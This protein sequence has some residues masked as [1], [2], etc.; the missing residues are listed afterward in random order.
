MREGLNKAM[1]MG[2]IGK[3][4]EKREFQSGTVLNFSLA[5]TERYKDRDGVWQDRTEW[6]NIAVWGKRAEGLSK[7]L[8]KGMPIYIEGKIQTRSWDDREGKKRYMTEIIARDV[9]LLGNKKD[10]RDDGYYR[11]DDGDPG[12]NDEDIPF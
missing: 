3:N 9:K 7:I 6:H 2:Y 1:L 4:P 10:R 8:E 5:T 12:F 11:N